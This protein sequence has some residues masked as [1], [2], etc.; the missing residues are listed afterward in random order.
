MCSS[1]KTPSYSFDF[2]L[3]LFKEYQNRLTHLDTTKLS[4]LEYSVAVQELKSQET[5]LLDSYYVLAEVY[6]TNKMFLVSEFFITFLLSI[7][8]ILFLYG[9]FVTSNNHC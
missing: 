4:E 1:F 3:N 7:L 8:A 5:I 9:F 6:I 2:N